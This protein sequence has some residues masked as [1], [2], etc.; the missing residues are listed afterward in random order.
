MRRSPSDHCWLTSPSTRFHL[1]Q[2]WHMDNFSVISALCVMSTRFDGYVYIFTLYKSGFPFGP[3][4][5][6]TWIEVNRAKETRNNISKTSLQYVELFVK[7]DNKYPESKWNRSAT[8]AK[9]INSFITKC[10]F[11]LF[12]SVVSLIERTKNQNVSFWSVIW[13][14]HHS[15]EKGW[16]YHDY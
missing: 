8:T 16:A 4:K 7:W 1:R 2:L 15:A 12:S 11:L 13:F 3:F 10:C 9:S 6:L 14:F 5:F